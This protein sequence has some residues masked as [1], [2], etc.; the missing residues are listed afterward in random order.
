VIQL[1]ILYVAP[2]VAA[3]SENLQEDQDEELVDYELSPERMDINV[4][5]LSADGDFLGDDARTVG[6]N[7]A[8]QSV[9]FEKPEDF[10]NHIKP[11]HGKGHINGTPVHNMLVDSGAIANLMP[12]SLYKKLGGTD[13]ELIRTNTTINSVGGGKPIPAKGVAS[14][15]LTI[16][17]KTL[18][19]AFFVAEVQG[20]HNLILGRDWIHASHCVPS[21][22]HQLLIQLVD[23]GIEVVHSDSS[24]QVAT[25]D[26]PLLGHMVLLVYPDVT[27]LIFSLLVSPRMVFCPSP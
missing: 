25:V 22:F 26:A 23:D 19:T 7:F 20:S 6:S 18:A 15:E 2:I 12:Y 9:I 14:M 24:A 10:V 4:V 16:G 21:S 17:S 3:E 5:Y 11:L 13:E 1:S 8:T 27:L